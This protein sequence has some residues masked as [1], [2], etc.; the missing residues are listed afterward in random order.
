MGLSTIILAKNEQNYIGDCIKKLN[1]SDEIIVIDN[2][3]TDDTLVLAQ[4]KG[5]KVFAVS[6]F[7]FSLLRYNAKNEASN[8]WLF[9]VD[10]DERPDDRLIKEIKRVITGNQDIA[11]YRVVR[12]NYYLGY[13][14]PKEEKMIRLINRNCLVSW[15]GILH[16]T[17]V[18]SGKIGDLQ[19][20]LLHYSHRNLSEMVEKTN[21]WSDYEAKLRYENKHPKMAW[22]RFFHVMLITFWRYYVSEGGWKT[23][24]PGL[25]ESIYQSFS[26]FITYAK[27]WEKQ[28]HG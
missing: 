7:N 25:L 16:E 8:D 20:K 15:H 6:G 2:G 4:K 1:F 11:A 10:A 12:K 13:P 14:W 3:S 24:I 18:I 22:W 27:L 28:Y 19:G 9:Y 23:G 17:P 21:A 5:A 26:I